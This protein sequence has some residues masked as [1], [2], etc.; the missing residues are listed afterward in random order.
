VR[1]HNDNDNDNDAST[2]ADQDDASLAMI[3]VRG[4]RGGITKII[5]QTINQTINQ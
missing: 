3:E 4:E 5:K 1:K 2:P